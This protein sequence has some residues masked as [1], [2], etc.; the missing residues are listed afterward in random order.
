MEKKYE[1][2]LGFVFAGVAFIVGVAGLTTMDKRVIAAVIVVCVVLAV[3]SAVYFLRS[4][5]NPAFKE[6]IAGVPVSNEILVRSI[7]NEAE[8]RAVS[9]LDQEYFGAESIDLPGLLGWWK[10][11][12]EGVHV[13]V[14]GSEIMGAVGIWPLSKKAFQEL[15]SGNLEDSEIKPTN[16]SKRSDRKSRSYWYFADIVLSKKYKGKKLSFRLLEGAIKRWIETG[17]LAPKIE[18]CAIGLGDGGVRLLKRFGFMLHVES[19]KGHPVFVRSAKL[20][21]IQSDLEEKIIK[22]QVDSNA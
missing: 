14:K 13:L 17:N 2:F 8:L 18:L 9:K 11:Y 10:R 12:P 19:K 16:L 7:R 20:A 1:R 3:L 21:E 4:S 5:K 22:P 6:L 15:V